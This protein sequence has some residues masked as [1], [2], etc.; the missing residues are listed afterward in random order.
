MSAHTA[1]PETYVNITSEFYN[2]HKN[3]TSYHPREDMT[4]YFSAPQAILLRCLFAW[5]SRLCPFQK[6]F[7]T[8]IIL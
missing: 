1:P 5:S 4:P 8:S 7:L 2:V 6:Q 3:Y